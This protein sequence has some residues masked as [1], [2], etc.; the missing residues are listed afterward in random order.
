MIVKVIYLNWRKCDTE[1]EKTRK[2]VPDAPSIGRGRWTGELMADR[3]D[4]Y[5]NVAEMNYIASPRDVATEKQRESYADSLFEMFNLH[6]HKIWN[7]SNGKPKRLRSL[8][9]GDAIVF[10]NGHMVVCQG[11]GWK[12]VSGNSLAFWALP[13]VDAQ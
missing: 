7:T 8:S 10:D 11:M 12:H 9:V 5:N 1:D 6:I 3:P 2:F 13:E 4:L